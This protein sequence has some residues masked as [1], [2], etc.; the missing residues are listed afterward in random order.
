MSALGK[1]PSV[2]FFLSLA[3]FTK[4]CGPVLSLVVVVTNRQSPLFLPSHPLV[5]GERRNLFFLALLLVADTLEL[6]ILMTYYFV[7]IALLILS[8]CGEILCLRLL[9]YQTLQAELVHVQV[10]VNNWLLLSLPSDPTS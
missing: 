4:F 7:G 5:E 2:I 9:R 6:V 10:I 3:H 8:L 1:A